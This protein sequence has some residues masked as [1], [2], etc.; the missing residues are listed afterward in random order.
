[1]IG[2]KE[3]LWGEMLLKKLYFLMLNNDFLIWIIPL[4]ADIFVFFYPVYL[5][6]LFLWGTI[7][8][9]FYYQ[10]S[11]LFTF[12]STLI[13]VLVNIFIQFGIDKTRPN[14]VLGLSDMKTETILHKFLP[15]SS[16]P[17]DHATISMAFATAVFVWGI[18]NKDKKFVFMGI[19]F[20][21]FSLIM[22]FARVI[23][24]VHWPT[25]VIAGS[26]VGVLIPLILFNEKIF[27]LFENRI[28]KN[29][30]KLF[31]KILRIK[32]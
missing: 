18:K 4:L 5:I 21:V 24:G 11:A 14:I 28:N 12:F 20:Y 10:S 2:L 3:P 19:V 22:S 29:L 1:M 23:S 25:D 8:K 13:S 32:N 27:A 7:K 31:N 26:V 30:V 17:S 16:F 6:I 9:K 15:S